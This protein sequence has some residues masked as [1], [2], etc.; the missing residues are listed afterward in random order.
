L[1]G[2]RVPTSGP[3]SLI[4]TGAPSANFMISRASSLVLAGASRLPRR[5][6]KPR[7]HP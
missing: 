3:S 7:G 5:C 4:I 2:P 1:G 6:A